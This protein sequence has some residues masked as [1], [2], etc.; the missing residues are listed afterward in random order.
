MNILFLGDI[1]GRPGR[2]A[3]RR[4]LPGLRQRYSPDFIIA[5]AENSAG[6]KG[7]NA[8]I[9]AELLGMGIHA[10]TGGNHSFRVKGCQELYEGEERLIR[11]ANFPPGAPGRGWGVYPSDAGF[12]VAVL[13]LCGRTFMSPYDDPWRMAADMVDELRRETPIIILDF[14]AEATSEKIAMGWWLDGRATAVIGTHTHVQTADERVL[15]NGTA[16]I[17]D[18][19]MSGPHD[20]VIGAEKGAV[21]DSL[22][23]LMP[24]RFEVADG[25]DLRVCGVFIEVDPLEGHALRIERVR[26]DLDAQ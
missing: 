6:G 4:A 12:P 3:V 26:V 15:P 18:A 22:L 11:P 21:L 5:N 16:Y 10:L 13:N 23:T 24:A 7:V 2:T 14:H 19:G 20:S 8:R 1:I 17:T 25:G 9:A